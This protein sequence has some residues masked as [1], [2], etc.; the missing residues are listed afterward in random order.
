MPVSPTTSAIM[1]AKT[2]S[3]GPA[4][5]AKPWVIVLENTTIRSLGVEVLTAMVRV[6]VRQGIERRCAGR[7]GRVGPQQGA[8]LHSRLAIRRAGGSLLRSQTRFGSHHRLQ[9]CEL[10]GQHTHELGR[11]LDRGGLA[12]GAL[13]ATRL[14]CTRLC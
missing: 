12:G 1:V 9:S 7:R 4:R 2:P 10:L 8:R 14:A 11:G 6:R 3:T 5:A 13:E